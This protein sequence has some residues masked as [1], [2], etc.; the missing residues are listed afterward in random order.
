M[1]NALVPIGVDTF[2]NEAL[3]FD[4]R[5]VEAVEV[6]D[7][8]RRRYRPRRLLPHRCG[9]F[10]TRRQARPLCLRR[11]LVRASRHGG[12]RRR[13]APTTRNTT[14]RTTRNVG[15]LV[16]FGGLNLVKKTTMC[17]FAA[18]ARETHEVRTAR[19]VLWRHTAQQRRKLHSFSKKL[20]M[21]SRILPLFFSFLAVLSAAAQREVP[22]IDIKLADGITLSDL[23]SSKKPGDAHKSPFMPPE[24]GKTSPIRPK[25]ADAVTPRG[26]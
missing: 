3:I 21:F 1:G 20:H 17:I 26:R 9:S 16:D 7:R 12:F 24:S 6:L 22:R 25:C 14:R 2:A 13:N 5:Q 10:G 18:R 8:K 23:E 19:A 15:R 4:A 11:T